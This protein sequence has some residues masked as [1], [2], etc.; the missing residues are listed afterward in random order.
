MA[1]VAELLLLVSCSLLLPARGQ[2]SPNW[3]SLD[4][5][6]LPAWYDQAKLGIFIHWGV[7]SV[8]SYG[9]GGKGASEWFWWNWK[10]AKAPW[11]VEFMEKNYQETFTYPDFAPQF[12]A[13]MYNP[14]DWGRFIAGSGAKLVPLLFCISHYLI[15]LSVVFFP[16]SL[17]LYLSL[18]YVVLTSKHH[19]GWTNWPSNTSWN[20]NAGAEGPHLDLVGKPLSSLHTPREMHTHT[21]CN[22]Q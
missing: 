15:I 13:E 7:F 4:A 5:R 20:W 2:Y 8:P 22:M 10:G 16:L 6:P 18:R 9:G 11:A 12:K 19:E 1:G 3:D 14:E 21:I 17:P